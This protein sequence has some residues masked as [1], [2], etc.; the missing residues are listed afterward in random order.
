MTDFDSV[1]QM[2]VEDEAAKFQS[3]YEEFMNRDKAEYL[4]ERKELFDKMESE[5]K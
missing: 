4:E 1:K 5:F 3:D 2:V